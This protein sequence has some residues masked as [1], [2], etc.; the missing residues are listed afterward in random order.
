LLQ[1]LRH[2][3][4]AVSQHELYPSRRGTTKRIEHYHGCEKAP[5]WLYDVENAI[6]AALETERWVGEKIRSKAYHPR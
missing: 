5:D 6:D 3:G 4:H 1:L 2:D